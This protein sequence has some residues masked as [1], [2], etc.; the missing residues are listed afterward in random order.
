M[1]KLHRPHPLSPP[2]PGRAWPA[3][4]KV[5]GG[6]APRQVLLQPQRIR[7]AQEDA[8]L[9]KAVQWLRPDLRRSTHGVQSD[10]GEPADSTAKLENAQAAIRWQ[11]CLIS[12]CAVVAHRC[13]GAQ[14][15]QDCTA[16][17]QKKRQ[18]TWARPHLISNVPRRWTNIAALARSMSQLHATAAWLGTCFTMGPVFMQQHAAVGA[19]RAVYRT[20]GW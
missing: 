20:L 6:P 3:R 4:A 19:A 12:T 7:E 14:P 1:W 13:Q 10:C 5:P 2:L 15:E 8:L 11:T 16:L 9:H 18:R 17:P